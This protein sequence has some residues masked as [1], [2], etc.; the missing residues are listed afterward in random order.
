MME[1]KYKIGDKVKLLEDSYGYHKNDIATII[2]INNS[3]EYEYVVYVPN[4]NSISD[5]NPYVIFHES[6]LE[7]YNRLEKLNRI[8]D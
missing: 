4:R 2:S 5:Y 6:N 8:L 7:P 1:S 3:Y